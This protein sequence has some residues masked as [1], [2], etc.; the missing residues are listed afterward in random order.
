MIAGLM[1]SAV[2]GSAQTAT[3]I[4]LINPNAGG[5]TPFSVDTVGRHAANHVLTRSTEF[6]GEVAEAT[7]TTSWDLNPAGG[8]LQFSSQSNYDGWLGSGVTLDTRYALGVFDTF[9]INAGNSGFVAGDNVQL[10][11]TLSIQVAAQTDGLKFQ[12]ASNFLRFT[13]QQR[14]P[15]PGFLGLTYSDEVFSFR[16]D[17][18]VYEFVEQATINGV[19]QF[20]NT[21]TYVN[22]QGNE[23]DVYNFDITLDGVVGETL[24]LG[25]LLGDFNPNVYDYDIMNMVSGTR[26]DISSAQED[27]GNQLSANISWDL[28][29]VVGFEGLEVLAASGFA[30]GLSA[31][32]EPSTYAALLGLFSL[33]MCAS[34]RRRR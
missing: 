3:Q 1:L 7:N 31:V 17:V 11:L 18:T 4:N 26:Q 10:N 6:N 15:T 13:V 21:V 9:T 28:E 25:M 29:A 2:W 5:G 30:S 24:E 12:T 33:G 20:D 23:A 19:T 22:G 16:Y 34:R 14:D 27:F 32:P 8:S